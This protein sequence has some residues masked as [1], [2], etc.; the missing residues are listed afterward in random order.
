MA[1]LDHEIQREILSNCRFYEKGAKFTQ[2]KPKGIAIEN[3]QFNYHL[4]QLV[5]GGLLAKEGSLYTL[6]PKGKSL[7]T[8]IDEEDKKA[9]ANFKVSVYMCAFVDGQILLARRLKHPQYGY[10]GLP[11]GKIRYGENMIET[12][13]REF[14][15]ETGLSADFNVIGNLRQI[16]KNAAGDVLEDGVFYVCFTDKV[17]GDLMAKNKEGEYFWIKP[18][19]IHTLEKVFRPSMDVIAEELE[20]R[21]SGKVSWDSKFIHELEPEPEDY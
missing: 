4:Q 20:D 7:V 21:I 16:R 17:K 13:K 19:D 2:L 3:D 14:T 8:N 12:A 6:T 15:E 11:S 1:S 5:K 18:E 9:P 10:S